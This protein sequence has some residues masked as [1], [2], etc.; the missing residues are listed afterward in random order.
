[1]PQSISTIS[2]FVGYAALQAVARGDSAVSTEAQAVRQAASSLVDSAEKSQALFG[3]KALAISQIHALANEC[4]DSGWDGDNA[5]AIHPR[6]VLIAEAFVRAIP[7]CIALPEVAPEPDG[8]LSLDWIQSR[9]RFFTLSVGVSNRL[10]YAWLDGA[11]KG[12]G[13]ARFDGEGIPTRVLEGICG[14]MNHGNVII[15]TC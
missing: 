15:G 3:A 11:D 8:C 12:N 1:M 5:A 6:A 2:F 4:S 14:I 13:V 10:A 7:D 9:N